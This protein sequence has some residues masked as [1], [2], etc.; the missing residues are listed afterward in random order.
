[1]RG[2]GWITRGPGGRPPWPPRRAWPPTPGQ[3][4]ATSATCWTTPPA[5]AVRAGR[6]DR[7]RPGRAPDHRPRLQS[8]PA[9][10]VLRRRWRRD[11][12]TAGAQPGR[13]WSL[14]GR[15][16]PSAPWSAASTTPASAFNRARPGPAPAGLGL[17]ALRLCRGAGAGRAAHRHPRRRPGRASA[18]GGPELRRR[19]SRPGHACQT[20]LARSINTVARAAGQR[21]RP[22]AGRRPRP[23][24]SASPAIPANP[25]LSIALGAY[26]VTLIDLTSAYQV[27]QQRRQPRRA[28]PDRRDPTPRTAEPVYRTPSA[29]P[30]PVYD[31]AGAGRWCA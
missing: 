16:A 6:A 17:Q 24:A 12:R 31:L 13:R 22:P 14:L 26:E 20:A 1:M 28:L 18:A 8:E 4:E 29:S 21:G 9:A 25:S 7:A 3:D 11:G 27:F 23:A 5:E 2:E 30:V 19:L 10:H 15:T